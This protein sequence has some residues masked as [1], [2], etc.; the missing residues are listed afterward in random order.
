MAWVGCVHLVRPLG[1][2]L[3]ASSETRLASMLLWL[4]GV[5]TGAPVTAAA[6]WG[7]ILPCWVTRMGWARVQRG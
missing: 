7:L 5:R 2:Q 3:P 6:D 1:L 4:Q